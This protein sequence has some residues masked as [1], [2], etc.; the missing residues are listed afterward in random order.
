M[1]KSD[2]AQASKIKKA[3][4]TKWETALESFKGNSAPQ[5][6][7]RANRFPTPV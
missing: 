7:Q 2:F 4:S 1:P 6:T 3:I 5:R